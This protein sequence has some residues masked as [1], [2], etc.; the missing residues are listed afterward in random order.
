[1][2]HVKN[3]CCWYYE[4]PR[5][6]LLSQFALMSTVNSPAKVVYGKLD[7]PPVSTM[8]GLGLSKLSTL[9]SQH[10]GPNVDQPAFSIPLQ[11]WPTHVPLPRYECSF[12]CTC[13]ALPISNIS[14]FMVHGPICRESLNQIPFEKISCEIR[15]GQVKTTITHLTREECK[16]LCQIPFNKYSAAHEYVQESKLHDAGIVSFVPDNQTFTVVR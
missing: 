3:V 7:I 14:N 1:M 8:V 4:H 10:S 5:D 9:D 6:H 15:I 16:L 2:L 12:A 13:H 11:I